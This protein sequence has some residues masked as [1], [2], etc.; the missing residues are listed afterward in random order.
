MGALSIN[1]APIDHAPN[2]ASVICQKCRKR[3]VNQSVYELSLRLIELISRGLRQR[4]NEGVG[5]VLKRLSEQTL[6][7]D[8]FCPLQ[9]ASL[10]VLRHLP[11]CTARAILVDAAIAAALAAIE[12]HLAWRRSPGYSDELLGAGFLDNYGWCE[13]I[14]S[15]GFFKGDDFRLGLLMLGPHRHYKDHFHPAPE[16]YWLLTG[17]SEW[18]RGAGGFETRE[19]GTTIWHPPLRIH[20]TK[21][22]DQPLLAV[23]AWTCDTTTPAKILEATYNDRSD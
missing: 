13:L 10:P 2:V 19:A 16:L 22:I 6:N 12:E 3:S 9:P 18:K 1:S 21:T 14:G 5:E 15:Q 20:A 7:E 4:P 17:P 23:W 8:R 11:E